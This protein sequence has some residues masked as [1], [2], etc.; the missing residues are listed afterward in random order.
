M[1]CRSIETEPSVF[2]RYLRMV[3]VFPNMSTGT[4]ITFRSS[5]KPTCRAPGAYSKNN[6]VVFVLMCV[7]KFVLT[8]LKMN[9]PSSRGSGTETALLR[10]RLSI[11][12]FA[13]K[14]AIVPAF[15]IVK[16][17]SENC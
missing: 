5:M 7:R 9:C 6:F 4:A 3:V 13:E 15:G 16:A 1:F 8:E 12:C 2:I 11:E 14:D 17:N 10:S